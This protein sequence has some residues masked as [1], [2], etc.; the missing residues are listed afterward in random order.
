[1]QSAEVVLGVLREN[2]VGHWRATCIERCPRGSE[3]SCVEKDLYRYLA[4]QLTR[5]CRRRQARGR[6]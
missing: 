5:C 3:G 4:A 2:G 6:T 1:M